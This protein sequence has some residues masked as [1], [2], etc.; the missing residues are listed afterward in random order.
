MAADREDVLQFIESYLLRN[1]PTLAPSSAKAFIDLLKFHMLV[2]YELLVKLA[3]SFID[4]GVTKNK[5]Y[6]TLLPDLFNIFGASRPNSEGLVIP[7][8]IRMVLNSLFVEIQRRVSCQP[9]MPSDNFHPIT[10]AAAAGLHRQWFAHEL[11]HSIF[12]DHPHLRD[13]FLHLL[14]ENGELR[15]D[16]LFEPDFSLNLNNFGLKCGSRVL[17]GFHWRSPTLARAL[18]KR[19]SSKLLYHVLVNWVEKDGQQR[20]QLRN[21]DHLLR[22]FRKESKLADKALADPAADQAAEGD[23]DANQSNQ[24]WQAS[25]SA[26][27]ASGTPEKASL[28]AAAPAAAG[29][30]NGEAEPMPIAS[31]AHQQTS[32]SAAGQLAIST[33]LKRKAPVLP[34][35][36]ITPGGQKFARLDSF[37]IPASSGPLTTGGAPA[38]QH[39]PEK[40]ADPHNPRF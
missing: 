11:E 38:L 5:I 1:L 4:E 18:G 17:R 40:A 9:A 8:G 31:M 36:P 14:V 7:A 33:I 24:T 21:K 23:D 26:A 10:V 20:P 3:P 13:Q 15:P 12:S 27:A 22:I 30:N 39:T 37:F 28:S 16:V 32:A 35:H 2:R 25:S 6:D 29:S 19:K 34:A